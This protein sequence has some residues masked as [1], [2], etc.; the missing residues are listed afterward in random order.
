MR[1]FWRLTVQ[2]P[3]QLVVHLRHFHFKAGLELVQPLLSHPRVGRG[4]LVDVVLVL[5]DALHV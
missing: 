5:H 4:A 3:L 2:R 1:H